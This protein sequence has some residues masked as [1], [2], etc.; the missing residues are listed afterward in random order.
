MS[1]ALQ[2]E[3]ELMAFGGLIIFFLIVEP[4]GLGA[5]LADRQGEAAP[6]ALSA[7][8]MRNRV[9]RHERWLR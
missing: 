9:L 2:K 4:H 5:T 8:R 1:V 6:V 7:L 3:I